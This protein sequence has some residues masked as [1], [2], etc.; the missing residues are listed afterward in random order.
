MHNS[1]NLRNSFNLHNSYNKVNFLKHIKKLII[2]FL[3]VLRAL[4]YRLKF[5][6]IL[7]SESVLRMGIENH[8]Y[9]LWERSSLPQLQMHILTISQ[10][11][12]FSKEYNL[13]IIGSRILS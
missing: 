9:V 8:K 12:I 7:T 5:T 10:K 11:S 2:F 13:Y 3:Y 1:Y 4:E 6:S